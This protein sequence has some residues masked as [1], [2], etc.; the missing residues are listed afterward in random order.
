MKS[1]L[2]LGGLRLVALNYFVRRLSDMAIVL[3]HL[4]FIRALDVDK[5]EDFEFGNALLHR[6]LE[7][8]VEVRE[9]RENAFQ[10]V[11]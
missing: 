2:L 6:L 8:D 9:V 7:Y 1:V 10:L 4:K 11:S 3:C 5:K